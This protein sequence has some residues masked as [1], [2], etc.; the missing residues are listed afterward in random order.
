MSKMH[1]SETLK[2]ACR[3]IL[4][5]TIVI[6]IFFLVISPVFPTFRLTFKVFTLSYWILIIVSLTLNYQALR[7]TKYVVNHYGP[8]KEEN[9][10]MRD[11]FARKDSKQYWIVWLCIWLS[12]FLLYLIG[13]ITALTQVY[14][15]SLFA[16]LFLLT[17]TLYD[18]W[19]DFLVIKKIKQTKNKL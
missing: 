17:I 2:F 15:L 14:L 6:A 3:R 1:T 18:F 12:S 11:M 5:L 7:W 13:A 19:N 16:S 4:P 10:I 9:P 8:Q